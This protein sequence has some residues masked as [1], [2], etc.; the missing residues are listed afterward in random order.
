MAK[1]YCG[2]L[3]IV[4][5]PSG[6]GKTTLVKHLSQSMEN[7]EISISHTT[8][9]MRPGERDGVDYHFINDEQFHSMVQ[10][11]AFL[12][13]AQV[14]NYLYGTAIAQINARLQ[15]GVDIL[16]DIDWQGAAQIKHIFPD[17]VSIF[18]IP[19]SIDAL[20]QRLLKRRQDK[21]EVISERMKKAQHEMSHFDEFDY[22]IVNDTFARAAADLHAI[23]V[24]DRLR[25]ER[26]KNKQVKLLSFLLS[27]Q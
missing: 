17:S 10:E 20:Q 16:L 6:G 8:R 26:Q 22:L 4:A 9:P 2:N 14:F 11:N 1:N 13:H 3:F 24:A 15:A 23:V 27:P 5:A 7:I 21:D 19:P 18:I 25:L 12:E